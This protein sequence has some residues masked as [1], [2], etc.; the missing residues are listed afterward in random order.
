MRNTVKMFVALTALLWA[1]G[2]QALDVQEAK[3]AGWIGE[4][5]DGYLGL[6]TEQ[7]PG[8][9]GKLLARVNQERRSSYQE[10]ANKNQLEL[11][12][13]EALAAQKAIQKT[14]PG[15]YIQGADGI[16]VKK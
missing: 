4:Q 6:V 9:I 1:I 7:A 13:V 16:W 12:A 15:Q 11:R 5:R 2:V 8:D 14:P 3:S 10:I